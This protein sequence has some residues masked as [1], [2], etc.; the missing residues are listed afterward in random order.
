VVEGISVVDAKEVSEVEMLEE[1][2]SVV[3]DSVDVEASTE[4]AEDEGPVEAVS[5]VDPAVE[6]EEDEI[7]VAGDEVEMPA[8]VELAE[9]E[10]EEEEEEEEGTDDEVELSSA[11]VLLEPVT[12]AHSKA[13][14]RGPGPKQ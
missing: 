4:D 12:A 1:A 11:S 6:L 8:E 13:P 9:V 2:V 10:T 14:V 7:E 5:D 3:G